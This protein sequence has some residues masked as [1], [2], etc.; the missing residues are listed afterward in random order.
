MPSVPCPGAFIF[1]DVGVTAYGGGLPI[2][3]TPA[4]RAAA[5]GILAA[6][7]YHA[8]SWPP[9]PSSSAT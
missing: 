8:V 9:L 1:E 6:E 3:T 4:F 2:L 5:T 7:A